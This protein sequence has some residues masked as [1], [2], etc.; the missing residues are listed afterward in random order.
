MSE[1]VSRAVERLRSAGVVLERGLSETEL[2]RV[3]ER[4]GF[5]FSLTHRR[6]L[7]TVLPL[8]QGWVDW[9]HG[10]HDEIEGRLAWPIDSAL[11]DVERNSFWPASWGEK[12]A[13]PEVA[14][15]H[16]RTRLERVPRLIPVYVHRF[17]AAGPGDVPSPVFSVYQTDVVYYGDNLLD[18]VAQEFH[19]PPAHPTPRPRIPFWSE[20][21]N[22]LDD[23]EL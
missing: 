20:L 6:F 12:P 17:L 11:F 8:G 22:G 19:A 23:D 9:R 4:F 1:L 10:E 3:E 18:Y 21:A 16:A 5:S 2:D 7:A 15:A 14:L 13:D